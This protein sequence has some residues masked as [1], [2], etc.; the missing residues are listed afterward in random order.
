MKG[1]F[2]TIYSYY[3]SNYRTIFRIMIYFL[4]RG[5]IFRDILSENKKYF[6]SESFDCYCIPH[7]K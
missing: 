6:L 7:F 3:V 1:P 5:Q 4:I 2:F